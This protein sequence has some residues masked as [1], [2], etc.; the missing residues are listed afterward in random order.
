MTPHPAQFAGKEKSMT[1]PRA[2]SLIVALDVP[3]A[4]KRA[5][6]RKAGRDGASARLG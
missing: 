4:K 2:D 5:R 3:S 1:I 6:L